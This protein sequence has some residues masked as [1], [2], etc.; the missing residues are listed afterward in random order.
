[1]C[2]ERLTLSPESGGKCFPKPDQLEHY[3]PSTLQGFQ[4]KDEHVTQVG[5]ILFEGI[6][7]FLLKQMEKRDCS[8]AGIFKLLPEA[9]SGNIPN[10]CS[11]PTWEG[12]HYKQS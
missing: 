6:G 5:P 12:S 10:T 1:M 2:Q 9:S 3:I 8:S 11:D 7:I 4:I